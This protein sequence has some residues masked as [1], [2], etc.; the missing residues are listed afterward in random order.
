MMATNEP[1]RTYPDTS[2]RIILSLAR[3]PLPMVTLKLMCVNARDT[4]MNLPLVAAADC[5]IEHHIAVSVLY[6][7]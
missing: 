7:R 1:G 2:L 3:L 5:R 4:G 6:R